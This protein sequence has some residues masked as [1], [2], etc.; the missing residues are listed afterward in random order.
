MVSIRK[1]NPWNILSPEKCEQFPSTLIAD[2]KISDLKKFS[3]ENLLAVDLETKGT[4][5]AY[6]FLPEDHK[7]HCFIQQVGMSDGVT[8]ATF[9]RRSLSEKDWTYLWQ[10]LAGCS[11]LIGHN[12]MFDAS[13]SY[14]ELLLHNRSQWD[15]WEEVPDSIYLKWG[16]CTYLLFKMLAGEGFPGQ[17]WGLKQAQKDLLGWE[18]TNEKDLDLWLIENGLYVGTLSKD[19]DTPEGRLV[20]YETWNSQGSRKIRPDKAEMWQAP[21]HIL[22]TYCALDAFSTFLLFDQVLVPAMNRFNEKMKARVW[23]H[24]GEWMTLIRLH[25]SQQMSGIKIDREGMSSYRESLFKQIEDKKEE[26]LGLEEIKEHIALFNESETDKVRDKEPPKFK[27]LKIPTLSEEPPSVTKAGAHSKSWEKWNDRR[28]LIEDMKERPHLYQ[29]ISGNWINWK[30]RVADSDSQN[31][32]SPTSP[33]ALEWLFYE[34]LGKE[35][36]VTTDSG[37]R[38]TNEKAKLGWGLP[39][40]VLIQLDAMEKELS[41]VNAVLAESEVDSIAHVRMKCPG[42]VTLRLA[43]GS[44]KK[45]TKEPSLNIQQS[46]KSRPYLECF[47]SRKGRAIVQ[48]DF[49]A[50]ENVVLAE[51]TRDKNMLKLYGPNSLKTDAYVWNGAQLPVIGKVFRDAGF[52]PENPDPEVVSHIKKHHKIERGIAKKVVLGKNYGMGANKL[53]SDLAIE[54]IQMSKEEAQSIIEGLNHLYEDAYVN[55]PRLLEEQWIG[56]RGYV[57]NSLGIP[58]SVE[59]GKLKD[60]VNRCTQST[61]HQI[62]VKSLCLLEEVLKENGMTM[63]WWPGAETRDRFVAPWILDFHDEHMVECSEAVVGVVKSS[64]VERLRRLNEWLGSFIP[65]EADPEIGH[66]LAT[67]KCEA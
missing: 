43:G 6:M 5:A 49:S 61:G 66:D 18:E 57:V 7:N 15:L 64:Y 27:K 8:A 16:C 30:Q 2:A 35:V 36:L 29:E 20:A 39:G 34:W 55:Y 52:D 44:M 31:H 3:Q 54:G 63:M 22:G 50:L 1:R 60:L 58:C 41:Y 19:S 25:V 65:L 37:G 12:I 24:I 59:H 26:F 21:P 42:T 40:V 33:L 14:G 10:W 53:R 48:S 67:F 17:S 51:I 45:N 56:N 62:T 9:D 28:L 23:E 4:Q 32:F 38:A 46:P 11:F 47:R 13:F